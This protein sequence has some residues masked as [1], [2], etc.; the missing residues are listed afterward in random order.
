MFIR[1]LIVFPL[2]G[3]L[4]SIAVIFGGLQAAAW[5]MLVTFLSRHTLP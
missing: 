5:C 3:I 2:S 4:L 1:A